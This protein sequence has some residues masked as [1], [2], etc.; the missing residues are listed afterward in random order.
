MSE[1]AA[2]GCGHPAS[3]LVRSTE[4]DYQFCELCEARRE[5]NDALTMEEHLSARVRQMEG[6]LKYIANQTMHRHGMA[7]VS[8]AAL[9]ALSKASQQQGSTHTQGQQNEGAESSGDSN[10]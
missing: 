9:A 6:A 4:S 8:G 10:G 2:L 3:L 7:H 5:R 1:E